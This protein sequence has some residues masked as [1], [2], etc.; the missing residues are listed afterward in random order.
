MTLTK[1]KMVREIGRRTQLRNRDVQAVV[2]T[3]VDVWTEELVA[4][5]KIEIENFI[6]LDARMIDRGSRT[7]L[8]RS[9][10]TAP[11]YI[12]RITLR[13]SKHLKSRLSQSESTNQGK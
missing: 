2:E 1:N 7:G 9:T 6:V 13:V 4:G 10:D 8:L 5:G 11:Q 3:L 12:N